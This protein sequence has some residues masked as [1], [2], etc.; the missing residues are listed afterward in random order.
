MWL[1]RVTTHG[2]LPAYKQPPAF[3]PHWEV[4]QTRQQLSSAYMLGTGIVT[5]VLV[6]VLKVLKVS[7]STP[8]ISW[9]MLTDPQEDPLTWKAL[10][11]RGMLTWKRLVTRAMLTWKALTP[12]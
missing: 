2:G 10:I 1:C 9:R 5:F 4:H 3:G 11:S 12:R 6:E 8:G 7:V